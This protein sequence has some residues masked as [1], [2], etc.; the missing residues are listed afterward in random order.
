[1]K[2]LSLR[3]SMHFN[4]M[5]Q[6]SRRGL[7]PER[8]LKHQYFRNNAGLRSVSTQPGS[9]NRNHVV[10]DEKG[11]IDFSTLHELQEAACQVYSKN[12]LFGTH[13]SLSERF[14]YLSYGDY[15]TMVRRCRGLLQD[16]GKEESVI[17]VFYP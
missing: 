8:R 4:S 17:C 11:F 16:L 12:D 13:S 15:G 3:P 2:T 7:R 5:I 10:L 6:A 1:M 9:F 14:E